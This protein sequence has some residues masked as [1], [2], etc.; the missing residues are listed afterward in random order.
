MLTILLRR[1]VRGEPPRPEQST[2]RPRHKAARP[3]EQN[4]VGQGSPH[5]DSLSR[6]LLE[7]H[8][9]LGCHFF[10]NGDSD[11]DKTRG[12]RR[13]RREFLQ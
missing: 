13:Q 2:A 11:N 1:I 10:G 9:S 12:L 8:D 4:R 3:A 5:G 6:H 7:L